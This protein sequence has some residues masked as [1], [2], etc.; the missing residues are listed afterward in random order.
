[1]DG[2]VNHNFSLSKR[3]LNQNSNTLNAGIVKKNN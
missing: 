2:Y 1:M 3:D